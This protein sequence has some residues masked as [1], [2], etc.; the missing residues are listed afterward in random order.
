MD[1]LLCSVDEARYEGFRSPEMITYKIIFMYVRAE[2]MH[3][4]LG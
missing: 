1:D 2:F 3:K 4:C